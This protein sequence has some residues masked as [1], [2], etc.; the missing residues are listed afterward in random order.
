MS[1]LWQR[2]TGL[3]QQREQ[4]ANAGTGFGHSVPRKICDESHL[5]VCILFKIIL[6][7]MKYDDKQ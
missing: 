5:T 3:L 6:Y 2:P 1:L 7:V 4:P